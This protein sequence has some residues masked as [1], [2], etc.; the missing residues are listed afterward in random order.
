MLVQPNFSNKS[1]RENFNIK[2]STFLN[3]FV[4]IVKEIYEN[5]KEKG[6]RK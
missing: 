1:Y 5:R 6:N 2:F 3:K 4:F